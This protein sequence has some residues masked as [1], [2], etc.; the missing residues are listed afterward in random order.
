VAI[1]NTTSFDGLAGRIAELLENQNYRVVRAISDT[2]QTE[3]TLVLVSDE[4]ASDCG[5]IIG[6][7]EKLVPGGVEERKDSAETLRY[8]ADVVVKLGADL[9]Q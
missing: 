6:K 2:T 3:K 9:A 5:V 1:I 8:R 7:L 4:A